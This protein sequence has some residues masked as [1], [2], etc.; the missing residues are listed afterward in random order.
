MARSGMHHSANFRSVMIFGKAQKVEGAGAKTERLK[1][2]MEGLYPGRWEHLRPV[3]DQ[4]I[5]STMVLSVPI[6]EA[7]AKIRTGQPVDDDEDYNLPVWA[8]VVPVTMETGAPEPDPRNLEG[9][10]LPDHIR[11]I[12]IG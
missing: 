5:K 10:S 4:E 11:D 1:H 12:K 6:E 7:S 2:F 9:V 3:T 8:G